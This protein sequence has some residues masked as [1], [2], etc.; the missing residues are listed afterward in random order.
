MLQGAG[1]FGVVGISGVAAASG[2][3]GE[4]PEHRGV[5]RAMGVQGSETSQKS[6]SKIRHYLQLSNSMTSGE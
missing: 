5:D 1:T 4:V 6:V 2:T 3:A